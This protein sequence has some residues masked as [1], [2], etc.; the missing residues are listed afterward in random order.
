MCNDSLGAGTATWNVP[1]IICAQRTLTRPCPS[2]S[3]S[4]DTEQLPGHSQAET[5]GPGRAPWHL[6]SSEETLRD[7]RARTQGK[8]QVTTGQGREQ[9]WASQAIQ[10]GSWLASGGCSGALP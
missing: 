7:I 9:P 5:L 2:L 6:E 10:K 8:K 1:I 4:E 3:G